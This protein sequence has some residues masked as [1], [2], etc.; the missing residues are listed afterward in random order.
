MQIEEIKGTE[1]ENKEKKGNEDRRKKTLIWAI[2]MYERNTGEVRVF[3]N[4]KRDFPVIRDLCLEHIK[5][6]TSLYTDGWRAYRKLDDLGFVHVDVE[7]HKGLKKL[8]LST[9]KMEGT[10]SELKDFAKIYSKAIPPQN[11][12]KFLREFLLRRQCRIKKS[13][14]GIETR[15]NKKEIQTTDEVYKIVMFFTN[16]GFAQERIQKVH[17]GR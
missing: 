13:K 5:Q 1:A 9:S 8:P 10:W 7:K 4:V 12:D 14:N 6:G 15:Q 17:V 2:G 3:A 16:R 11:C